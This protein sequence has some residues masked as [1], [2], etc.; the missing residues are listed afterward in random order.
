[1]NKTLKL[2]VSLLAIA[3]ATLVNTSCN[4][5]EPAPVPAPAIEVN[6][7]T[8]EPNV[9]ELVV[10]A[11]QTLTA[12]VSP[13]DATT[14]IVTWHSSDTSVVN[15][16]SIGESTAE[17]MAKAVGKASIVVITS[18]DKTDTCEVTVVEAVVPLTGITIT[19]EVDTLKVGDTVMYIVTPLPADAM[20][21]SLV[22]SSSDTTVAIV[23]TTGLVTA[24][25]A[26]TTVVT[27]TSG[28]ISA[29]VT[30]TIVISRNSNGYYETGE[31]INF[32]RHT[33]GKGID[34]IILGDGFDR[35]DCRIGGVYEYNCRKL[36]ELFLSMPVIRD[37]KNFFNISARV[38]VSVDR[39][40]RNCVNTPNN[41]PDNVYGSG[42]PDLRW[43]R[44]IRNATLTA[45]ND[46]SSI[47]FMGNGAIGGGA[48]GFMAV[49]SANE[50][51]KPFWMMHEFVGHV[52]GGLPDLYYSGDQPINDGAK[53][54]FDHGHADTVN[55]FLM[56]DW[57][58]SP[59][60][61]FWKDF[62]DRPGYEMVYVYQAG[63]W[64]LQFGSFYTCENVKTSVMYARAAHYTVM[65]R[66]QLWR[67]IHARAGFTTMTMDDFI[68]YDI[69]NLADTGTSFSKFED[70]TDER[71]WSE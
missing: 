39:G 55:E 36:T 60:E 8:I 58:S 64:D 46:E 51:E 53:A 2:M 11:K 22:W 41:C 6:S 35:E 37:Y 10:A 15:V 25:S 33:V 12:T 56:F 42:H 71:I 57:R 44:I 45:G 47:I 31:V 54:A 63:Y 1:M 62:I 18:N 34:I 7:V 28:N 4:K 32:R 3:T 14:K 52:L 23:S 61:V 13:E 30:V 19:P 27:V 29:S 65:E 66:Y 5:E 40:A 68:A 38:D 50:P 24:V 49:Y 20:D 9:L 48:Y 17:V 21:Y 59:K 43:N 70:W 16:S 26:G 69:I 67:K